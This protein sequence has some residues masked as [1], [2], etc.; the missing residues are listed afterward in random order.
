MKDVKEVC[1][2]VFPLETTKQQ[3]LRQSKAGLSNDRPIE[4]TTLMKDQRV[5]IVPTTLNLGNA[6]LNVIVHNMG[7]IDMDMSILLMFMLN[8]IQQKAME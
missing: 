5:Q 8:N 1:I 7:Y 2:A 4:V 3:G 6:K